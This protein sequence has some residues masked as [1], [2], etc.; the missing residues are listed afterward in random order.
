MKSVKL[1]IAGDLFPGNLPYNIGH[2]IA[3]QFHIHNGNPWQVNF[4]KIFK[5]SD[6]SFAN[7]ESPLLDENMSPNKKAFAGSEKFAR[8]IKEVG[9]DIVSI[10]NNHILEQKVDGFDLT[11][12]HLKKN[13][14]YY[15]GKYDSGLSNIV[16]IVKNNIKLCFV[17]FNAIH[18]IP[19]PNMYAS[20]NDEVIL[21]T[22]EKMEM[23]NP[24]YK[25]LSFHWGNEYINIPSPDQ[26][27]MAH[28][29]IDYGADII[30][31][32]HPHVI[33]P[34]EK[35][36]HGLI[37]YSL[38]NFLFDMT[39]AFNVRLGMIAEITINKDNPLKYRLIPTYIDKD[40]TPTQY[41]EQNLFNEKISTYTNLMQELLKE[42]SDNYQEYYFKHLKKKRLRQRLLM[43]KGL[44]FSV[45]KLSPESRKVIYNKI[46]R[47]LF[48]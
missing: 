19:N 28:K 15:I 1:T 23:M 40:Y 21:K 16:Q 10:A 11:I 25:I 9:I 47:K 37:F 33:Q 22:I 27:S 43:K 38:G 8:F 36:K 3:S 6:I 48:R 4:T 31:G 46:K 14:I 7:L 5:D 29:F 20:F 34:V 24:D 44:L 45:L 17:A 35:Y 12:M 26:I 13:N 2:G 30:I 32:H 41:K 18:D 42:S 39:Y